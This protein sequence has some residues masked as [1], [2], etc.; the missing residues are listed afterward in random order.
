MK[1]I[2]RVWFFLVLPVTGL[3]LLLG[4]CAGTPTCSNDACY[5]RKISSVDPYREG[6][7]AA[8]GSEAEIREKEYND[9]KRINRPRLKGD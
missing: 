6:E 4:S 8:W 2:T 5:D 1:R 3:G 9:E 7:V